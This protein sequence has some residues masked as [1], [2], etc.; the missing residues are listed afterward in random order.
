MRERTE[1]G[2]LGKIDVITF[3]LL[4]SLIGIG[5]LMVYAVSYGEI[6][7]NGAG[8]FFDTSAGKQAIWIGVS[9][10]VFTIIILID[11][12]FWQTFAYLIYGISVALL[13]LVL[14]LGVTIKGSTSWFV[15]GGFSFQPSEIAKF[16]TALAVS[17]FLSSYRTNLR[18]LRSQATVFGIML[19]PVVLIMLQPDAGSALVFFSF[20]LVL[21]REGLSP[22]YYLV[23]FYCATLMIL[24]LVVTD[25]K[26]IVQALILLALLPMAFYFKQ[27][28]YWILSVVFLGLLCIY[29]DFQG[30]VTEV[31][32]ACILVFVIFSYFQWKDRRS[33]MVSLLTIALIIGS[34]ISFGANYVFNN[35]LQPHQQDRIDVWLRPERTDPKGSGYNLLHSKMAISSGGLEGKGF[36]NGTMT[37]LNYVPEQS[38]DFIFCTIGEEQGFV[39]SFGIIAIFLLLLLRITIIA[40]RQRSDFSRHYAYCVAG[41]LFI[42]FFVNIGM[43]MGLMPIIGIPLPFIS[44]GGS[45]LL[46]FTIMIA[47]LLKLDSNRGRI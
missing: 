11:W 38:T 13:V 46:V 24:G 25:V 19:F 14:F 4:L 12:K 33:R 32:I 2:N 26:F 47:V 41:I 8:S 35:V 22:T 27:R 40:E 17:S 43:T 21:F 45:S 20:L 31:L 18:Y 34:G 44:K 7:Q 23:G 15:I 36:L 3:W 10:F 9:F 30:H 16:G 42:H 29:I 6:E 37:K 1:T 5:F 39:G 28:A